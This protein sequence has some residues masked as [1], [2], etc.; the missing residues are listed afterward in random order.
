MGKYRLQALVPGPEVASP[1]IEL[2]V[3]TFILSHARSYESAVFLMRRH[4]DY[5]LYLSNT[6]ADELEQS[7]Q[8]QAL[9]QVVGPLVWA[10][11]LKVLFIETF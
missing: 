1:E 9:W 6:G 10:G 3:Q 8:L 7:H 2:R 4:D 11:Q 5:L